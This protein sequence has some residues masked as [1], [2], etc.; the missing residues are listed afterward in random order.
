[1]DDVLWVGRVSLTRPVATFLSHSTKAKS[2]DWRKKVITIIGNFNAKKSKMKN[3]KITINLFILI[4]SGTLL[5]CTPPNG[6]VSEEA[7]NIT[8][9]QEISAEVQDHKN[10]KRVGMVIKIKPEKLDEYIALHADSNAGVRHLLKKYHM[11]N[12]SIYMT[13]LDD[14]NYYEFGYWEY[15]GDDY[16]G[17]M[18][19]LDDEPE[20]KAWLEMC[21]PMQVPLNGETS[22][23]HMERIYANY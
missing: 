8:S 1:M 11:R 6:K 21:D 15:W 2:L 23:R 9:N 4:L 20:N 18:K 17:D 19:K 5:S 12:F 13:Q 7:G 16:E 22:W 14:G 10:V 3:F